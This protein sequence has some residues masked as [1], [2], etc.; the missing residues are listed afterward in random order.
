[1]PSAVITT[2]GWRSRDFAR[3]VVIPE[4]T[5]QRVYWKGCQHLIL[6]IDQLK[7]LRQTQ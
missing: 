7:E 1:M 3:V 6:H 2:A 4:A 5:L